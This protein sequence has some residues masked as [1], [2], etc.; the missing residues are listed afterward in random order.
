MNISEKLSELSPEGIDVYF[1]NVG[2]ELLDIA[3]SKIK[4]NGKI[5][6]CGAIS[7][8]G[9]TNFYPLRNYANL[10]SRRARMEG[11]IVSDFITRFAEAHKEL[12]I[13]LKEKRLKQRGNYIWP[14][15]CSGG[16]QKAFY[17]C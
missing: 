5:V 13:W 8:Y 1:D 14:G 11:F 10:I 6:L 15:K 2:G 9:T 16:F 3:L 12:Y 17:W 4:R 7:V